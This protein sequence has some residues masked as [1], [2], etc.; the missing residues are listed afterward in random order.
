MQSSEDSRDSAEHQ[1]N[2]PRFIF[3]NLVN[4]LHPSAALASV[5]PR[6]SLVL[7][8]APRKREEECRS[9]VDTG[10][11]PDVSAVATDDPL[12]GGESDPGSLEFLN[13]M[14]ALKHAE[15]LSGMR[16]VEAGAIVAHEIG[17]SA[18]GWNGADFDPGCRALP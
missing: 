18:V 8:N 3:A 17:A 12:D 16:H 6:M 9:L 11:R 4:D 2:R 15:E 14:Q 7:R 5:R 13:G 1:S 10:F